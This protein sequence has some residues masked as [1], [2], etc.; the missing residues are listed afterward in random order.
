MP[1]TKFIS[2]L[3]FG[4]EK[5]AAIRGFD[6]TDSHD[7]AI[8]RAWERQVNP[9]DTVWVLGDLSAGGRAAERSALNILSTLP[10]KKR[11]IAGNHDSVAGIHRQFSPNTGLFREVFEHIADFGRIRLNGKVVLLSHYPYLSQGDGPGRGEARYTQFRLPDEGQ[12]LIHGHTHHQHPTDGSVTGREL[13]VSWDAWR[14]LVDLGDI[15]HWLAET[16]E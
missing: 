12:R 9:E 13:C 16:S 4:H 3:H 7:M 2:D 1:A 10:G 15:H 11:L 8:V 14:R 6:N 5:V